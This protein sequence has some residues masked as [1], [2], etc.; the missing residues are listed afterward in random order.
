MVP[1]GLERVGDQAVGRIDV[2]VA[3]PRRV[4]LVLR[5][6]DLELAEAIDLVE[7]DLD[8]L[9]DGQRDVDGDGVTVATRS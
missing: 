8:L 6:L 1:V 9:L 7:S 3:L 2:P 4:G 5:P